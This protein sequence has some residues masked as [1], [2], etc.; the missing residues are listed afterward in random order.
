MST[1]MTGSGVALRVLKQVSI[2]EVEEDERRV[3]E[4]QTPIYVTWRS[5]I[6]GNGASERCAW[7]A[8]ERY[9]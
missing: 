2:R 3:A 5:E 4:W 6:A 7:K 1:S 9:A 8:S